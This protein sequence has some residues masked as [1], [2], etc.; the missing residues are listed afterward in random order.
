MNV[1]RR[2]LF[3]GHSVILRSIGA[4]LPRYPVFEVITLILPQ[5]NKEEKQYSKVG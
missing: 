3:H 4:G 2:I 5:K 1:N